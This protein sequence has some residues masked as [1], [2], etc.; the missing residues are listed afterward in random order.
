MRHSPAWAARLWQRIERSGTKED[1]VIKLIDDKPVGSW[2]WRTRTLGESDVGFGAESSAAAHALAVSS[3]DGWDP[4]EV[5]L[6]HID[7]PRRNLAGRD[8]KKSAD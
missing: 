4:W 6:L 2:L 5:W 1:V 3:R 8:L 7:Q